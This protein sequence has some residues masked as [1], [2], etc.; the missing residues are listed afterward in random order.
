MWI[1]AGFVVAAGGGALAWVDLE[2]ADKIA[3]VVGGVC[4]ALGLA[5]S[6]YGLLKAGRLSLESSAAPQIDPAG[7]GNVISGSAVSG[8]AAQAGSVEGPV[9][10]GERNIVGTQVVVPPVVVP[11]MEVVAA[12]PGLGRVPAGQRVFVGRSEELRRLDAVVARTGRA[13]VVAVHG[14]G[15]IGKS[16]LV[17]RFA[18]VHETR[19]SLV[20]WMIADSPAAMDAGLAE[21]AAAVA[22]Q[23]AELPSE[24]RTELGV[25]WLATHTGWLLVLD[26]LSAPKDAAK[27]LARV[28]TGTVVITSRHSVGWHTL[29]E[30][31]AL[32]VLSPDEAIDLMTRIIH[33]AQPSADLTGMDRLCAELGR[34]P[35]AVEQAAAYIAQ[36]RITPK[37]Y[38]DLLARSPARMYTATAEGTDAQRTMAMV[39]HVTLECLTDTP[40]AGQLLR[41][42]AWYAPDGIPRNRLAGGITEP[43]LSEA[44]GRLAAYSMIT[45]TTDTVAVHRLV[46]AVTRAPDPIDPHRQPADIATARDRTTTSLTAAL[47]GLHPENPADWPIY[48]MVLFH[49]RALLEHTTPHCDTTQTSRLLNELGGYLEG[50]GDAVTAVAYYTRA[51]DTCHRLNG[52]DHADTL[53]ARSNLAGAYESLGDLGRAIPLY[54]AILADE[55]RVLGA[56]DPDTLTARSNLAGAYESLGDLGRAIPLY[57]ATI[58]DRERVLGPDHLNT[59][60]SRSNLASAYRAAGDLGRAILMHEAIVADCERVLGLDHLETLT[61][62]NNLACAYRSVRDLGRAIPLYEAT[63]AYQVRVLGL[64]HRHT[65]ITRSNLACAYESAGDLRR[66]IPLYEA[67]LADEVRLLGPNHPD[68]LIS[69]NNLA[70]AYQSAGDLGRA[71]PLYQATHTDCERVLGPDHPTT[72]VVRRNTETA[73]GS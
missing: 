6:A 60:E 2:S 41:Q 31:V 37:A 28:R 13:V 71:I 8:S 55:V 44:L 32:D 57:E 23:T 35:L 69:R 34:L 12:V 38:L 73:R 53:T 42:M 36:T 43:E 5:L 11:E 25:R 3:S 18:E 56:D 19:F 20:W 14:L 15:G 58:A 48:R 10:I 9:V 17:A 22:P 1:V 66:A 39:W 61:S 54:E 16:T 68:T 30:P 21:L 45:L 63:L 59:L 52:P 50:Q 70:S 62:R 4:G 40:A 64:N 29:A 24:Q 51:T 65:L 46:Q 49:V 47:A 72:K 27:L 67:I 33:A 7:T 26:N